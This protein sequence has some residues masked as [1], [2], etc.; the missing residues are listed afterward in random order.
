MTGALQSSSRGGRRRFPWGVV[1]AAGLV[2]LVLIGLGTWQ[3]QRLVWK[4]ALL[5]TIAERTAAVPVPLDAVLEAGRPIA[6]LEYTP[7]E[8]SGAFDH[9]AERHFFA[10]WKGASGYYVYTPLHLDS[11]SWLFVNRGFVPFERKDAATRPAGQIEGRVTIAGLLRPPLAGKP[12]SIVPD[13]DTAKNIFYWKDIRAMAATAGLPAGADVLGLFVD[14]G[15]AANPGGL[16]I[17]G[18]TMIDLPNN[19]LQYAV[20]WYGLAAALLGVAIFYLLRGRRGPAAG[21]EDEDG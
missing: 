6:E 2:F 7:V 12:S 15:P 21:G 8:V 10:T 20:T 19:H 3:V 13:N 9:A 16:P 17:G 18:V 5:A 1:A 14:A 11:G 4:E